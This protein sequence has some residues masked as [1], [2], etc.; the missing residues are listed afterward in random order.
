MSK[1]IAAAALWVLAVAHGYAAPFV[2]ADVPSPNADRCVWDGLGGPLVNNVVVD[3]VRGSSQ[4]GN[5]ICMRDIA[6]AAVG[7]NDITLALRDSTSVW[8]DSIAVP[9][10][11][12]RPASPT[13]PVGLRVAP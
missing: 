6:A 7:S 8:E 11:F 9:F 12:V 4:Y 5:R 10:S 1:F 3:A 2:V 13:A